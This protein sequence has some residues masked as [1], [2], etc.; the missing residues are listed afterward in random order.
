MIGHRFSVYCALFVIAAAVEP[1]WS[2]ESRG[3]VLGRVT[4][5]TGSV[6]PGATIQIANVETGVTLKGATNGE[7][8]YFFS[9]LIP[10]MYSVTAEREGFKRIVRNGIEVN[11]NARLELNLT[12]E[13][14]AVTDTVN[15]TE[16]APLLDTTN[17][18]IGR[19]VDGR[20][21]RELPLNH[22]NP[23]NLIRLSGG[24]NF[25]DQAIKDQPWQ[26]LNT[27]YAMAGSRAG[28]TEFTLDGASNTLHDQARGSVAAAW[29]PPSDT[30]AEF[31][32]RPRPS[33]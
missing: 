24:V 21:T 26:T 31:R 11:V 23:F 28:K 29:T 17:A 20:E 30:V 14:G 2:Q 7:G 6:V 27:N 15:V 9:F 12:L 5:S 32:S 18:S 25:T 16:E 8:N 10:G 1:G 3:T 4:D 22:G 19:V 13:I 33:T